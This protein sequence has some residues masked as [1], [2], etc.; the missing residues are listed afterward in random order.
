MNDNLTQ[1]LD[2]LKIALNRL[3]EKVNSLQNKN[4]KNQSRINELKTVI[5]S[6]YGRID[7]ALSS[8]KKGEK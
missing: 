7:M 1:S 8:F 3:S 5:S 4:Q 2:N 6:A